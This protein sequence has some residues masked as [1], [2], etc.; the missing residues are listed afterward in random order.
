MKLLI[1]ELEKHYP[2]LGRLK[3][4]LQKS[5][6]YEISSHNKL[7]APDITVFNQRKSKWN[8]EKIISVLRQQFSGTRDENFFILGLMPYDIYAN[9]LNF[10]YGLGERNGNFA[11]I[12][13]FRLDQRF[14]NKERDDKLFQQRVLKES[15]HEIGHMMGLEHCK[16]KNCVMSFSPNILFVDRKTDK[17]CA[18]CE[19]LK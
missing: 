17:F 4:G 1:V 10:V 14:Y 12:S 8:S 13:Y 6:K 2:H 15:I 9:S 3:E 18:R 7:I 5:L 11:V 16:N 19:F